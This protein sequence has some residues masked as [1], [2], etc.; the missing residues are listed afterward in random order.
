MSSHQLSIVVPFL[1]VGTT[2]DESL[3]KMQMTS[4]SAAIAGEIMLHKVSKTVNNSVK[5]PAMVNTLDL[6]V[7]DELVVFVPPPAE[8]PPSQKRR[9]E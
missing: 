5:F 7:G 9:S 3:A 2:N 1:L 6:K 8:Q 4:V